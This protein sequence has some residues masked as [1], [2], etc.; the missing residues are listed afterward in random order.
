MQGHL[1]KHSPPLPSPLLPSLPS[2]PLLSPLLPSLPS[3]P[4]SSSL[5]SSPPL[6]SPLLPSSPL[7]SP[8]PPRLGQGAMPATS[9]T[10]YA[11]LG[12]TKLPMSTM[13]G[14]GKL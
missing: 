11:M 4:L 9:L 1:P 10:R 6:S 8:L 12:H 3:P 13:P 14:G 5:L 7:F 2:P